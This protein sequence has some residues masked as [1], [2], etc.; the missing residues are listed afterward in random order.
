MLPPVVAS[1][2]LAATMIPKNL[3]HLVPQPSFPDF[4]ID[5]GLDAT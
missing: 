5:I 3:P 4:I 2:S 1:V